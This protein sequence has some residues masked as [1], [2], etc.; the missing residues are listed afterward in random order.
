MDQELRKEIVDLKNH[1]KRRYDSLA[2]NFY[3]MK[4]SLRYFSVKKGLSFTS[5]D[6]SDNFPVNA[7]VAG[8]CLK[9]LDELNVL[10][11]RGSRPR[12]MP[13]KVDLD[14]LKEIEDILKEEHEIEEFYR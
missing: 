10:Q 12:Y 2:S 9:A 11:P 5:S 13:E 1:D 3:I 7:S 14:R 8:S 6:V 4:A